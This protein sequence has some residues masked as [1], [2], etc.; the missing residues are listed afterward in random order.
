MLC[1]VCADVMCLCCLMSSANSYHSLLD[2]MSYG[3]L[4]LLV[5]CYK[6]LMATDHHF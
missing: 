4:Y 2:R 6:Y 1:D 3:L 5:Q